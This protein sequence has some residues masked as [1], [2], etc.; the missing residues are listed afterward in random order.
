MKS[1][2]NVSNFFFL[3]IF[4]LQNHLMAK[5]NTNVFKEQAWKVRYLVTKSP[6]HLLNAFNYS[7]NLKSATLWAW[8][9]V[10]L[11][12]GILY[13]YDEKLLLKVQSWGKALNIEPDNNLRP[14]IKIGNIKIFNGP[15]DV[16]SLLYFLG[17]GWTHLLIASGFLLGG[18]F[19]NSKRALATGQQILE[20]MV[21]S[22][23]VNQIA[24]RSFGRESP[25]KKSRYRG[26]WRPFPSFS[27]YNKNIPKYDAMPSGHI[28]VT[29]LSFTII[30]NNYPE[31]RYWFRPFAGIYLSLLAL[32]M[33]N[34]SVHWA[35]DYP[36]GIAMGYVFGKVLSRQ[37]KI[38]KNT[39][40]SKWNI[41]PVFSSINKQ[42]YYGFMAKITF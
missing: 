40:D 13:Y 19:K 35:S 3:L 2:F 39:N 10:F 8:S 30:D 21:S 1:I 36:L 6:K 42:Y 26:A 27:E 37:P 23:I 5:N 20:G 9:G 32:Q 17:D 41:L 25:F 12:T 33:M 24:K 15:T 28:M 22:T 4:F 29:S 7:F 11:S 38:I 16:G 18:K 34:N 14:L 31:Q